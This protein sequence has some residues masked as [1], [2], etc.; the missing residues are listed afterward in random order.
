MASQFKAART[1]KPTT[2][3]DSGAVGGGWRRGGWW[4]APTTNRDYLLPNSWWIFPLLQSFSYSSKRCDATSY[5]IPPSS[6]FPIRPC[7]STNH[8]NVTS[9]VPPSAQPTTNSQNTSGWLCPYY[10]YVA[11]TVCY[12]MEIRIRFLIISNTWYTEI[13]IKQI[14]WITIPVVIHCAVKVADLIPQNPGEYFNWIARKGW[15][16]DP[17]IDLLLTTV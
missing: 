14:H 15:K 2:D 17:L 10:V 6:F 8:P 16:R 12:I 9:A 5:F 3:N 13:S 7:L 11:V 4:M 1:A